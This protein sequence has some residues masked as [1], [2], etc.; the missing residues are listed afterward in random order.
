MN[1]L[2]VGLGSIGKKHIDAIKKMGLSCNIYALRSDNSSNVENGIYNIYNFDDIKVSL[3]FAIISNPTHLHYEY[4]DK[5]ANKG[6]PLFIEKPAIHSL[7]SSDKLLRL[8]EEKKLITYVAC[9]LRFHPCI[10]FL[11]NKIDS[12][13][14]RINEVNIYCG[15][16]LPDWRPGK[17][18]RKIYSANP[19]MGGGVHLDLF[20]EID[21]TVWLLG[22]P[23]KSKLVLRSVSSLDI[24]AIDY[25]NYLLEYD[26]FSVSIILNYY[27]KKSKREIEI[28]FD[29]KIWII[30]LNRNEVKND[31]NEYLFKAL[32]FNVQETYYYQLE[33]FIN[34]LNNNEV[35][36]NSLKESVDILKICLIND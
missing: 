20:H 31:D 8:I 3:D 1:I 27:R 17:D 36:M 25:A 4:I 2:I 26:N 19:E 13:E 7:N 14:L 33:Y 23:N 21:Y 9:N 22:L 15:S 16:Y 6:I 12:L 32:N 30:D 28:V 5:L 24:D 35:P 18:F 11:K 10:N 34:C 29:D